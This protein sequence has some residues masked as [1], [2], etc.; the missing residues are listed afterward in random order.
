MIM[1]LLPGKKTKT[2]SQ[3]LGS[4]EG[5]PDN[6]FNRVKTAISRNSPSK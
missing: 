5:N 6:Y 4:R 2:Q 3:K 1:R